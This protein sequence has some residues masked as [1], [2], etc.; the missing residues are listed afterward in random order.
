VPTSDA[1]GQN[2]ELSPTLSIF[3]PSAASQ[4]EEVAVSLDAI[5]RRLK[6]EILLMA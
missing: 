4:N 5:S 1:F 3:K 2:Q 6:D